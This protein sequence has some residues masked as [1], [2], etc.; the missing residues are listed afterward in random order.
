MIETVRSINRDFLIILDGYLKENQ[1]TD[2]EKIK[3]ITNKIA[4]NAN[5]ILSLAEEAANKGKSTVCSERMDVCLNPK[6]TSLLKKIVKS[7][8]DLEID[9]TGVDTYSIQK[10][11]GSYSFTTIKS[12]SN[13]QISWPD[14]NNQKYPKPELAPFTSSMEN[15]FSL[16][17]RYRKLN[18]F[19][20]MIL[21][22]GGTEIQ[23]HRLVL[24][25]RSK[26]FEKAFTS[27]M[28][29]SSASFCKVDLSA[30]ESDLKHFNEFIDFLYTDQIEL[31]G[32]TI[33]DI[34][35]LLALAHF[36]QVDSLLAACIYE[37]GEQFNEENIQEIYE[38]G[39]KYNIQDLVKLAHWREYQPL[40]GLEQLSVSSKVVWFRPE[41]R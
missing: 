28:K 30:M 17:Q 37:L 7:L 18:Q 19:T 16:F 40:E 20:D 25:S 38:I 26:F 6:Y 12:Y 35:S 9:S 39:C 21:S 33:A 22:C 3:R 41:R 5:G 11:T 2:P 29:E 27:G 23:V 36:Y 34:K 24:A 10:L 31:K 32:R 4:E 8:W 14:T 13:F 15:D 1:I